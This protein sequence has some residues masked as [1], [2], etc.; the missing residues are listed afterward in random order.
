MSYLP[1]PPSATGATFTSGSSVTMTTNYLTINKTVGSAT[2][3]TLP[4]S[5]STWTFVYIIKDQ[6]GDCATN[7]ITVT[8]SSGTID[9]AASFVMNV[10]RMS[11][12]F[13]FDGTNYSVI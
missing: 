10:N 8:P 1:N 12:S 4:V 5:P 7:N 13:L 6:K 11:A 9:G 3:V 2:A